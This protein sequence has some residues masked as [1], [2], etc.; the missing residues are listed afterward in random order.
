MLGNLG[1]INNFWWTLLEVM[2]ISRTDLALS[3]PIPFSA[4]CENVV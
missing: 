3:I 4:G 1:D 2:L